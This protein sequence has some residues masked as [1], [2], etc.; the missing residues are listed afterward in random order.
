M[1]WNCIKMTKTFVKIPPPQTER[2]CESPALYAN[3]RFSVPFSGRVRFQHGLW[4]AVWVKGR[5]LDAVGTELTGHW[6]GESLRGA[7]QG[8][9]RWPNTGPLVFDAPGLPGQLG[10][11]GRGECE[12][13]RG[14]KGYLWIWRPSA[15]SR[16]RRLWSEARLKNSIDR[17]GA[18]WEWERGAEAWDID[19]ENGTEKKGRGW[20]GYGRGMEGAVKC[21]AYFVLQWV[22][23]AISVHWLISEFYLFTSGIIGLFLKKGKKGSWNES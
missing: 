11:R 22:C 10:G 7:R 15:Q 2:N 16:E 6:M 14:K 1:K 3:T 4:R 8:S 13:C 19:I 9:W 20:E 17:Q 23:C 12:T 5:R 18:E 21:K